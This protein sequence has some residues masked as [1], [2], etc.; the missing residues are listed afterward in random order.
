MD[1]H[2][3]CLYL[4]GIK[5]R[6]MPTILTLFLSIIDKDQDYLGTAQVKLPDNVL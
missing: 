2:T 3:P 1:M 5:K 4:V 6:D